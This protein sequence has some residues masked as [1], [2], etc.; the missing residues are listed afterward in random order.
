MQVNQFYYMNNSFFESQFNIM[1]A[2]TESC[3]RPILRRN[4]GLL[5]GNIMDKLEKRN[6][7]FTQSQ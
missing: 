5:K 7:R 1:S 2:D 4:K 3:N 6:V